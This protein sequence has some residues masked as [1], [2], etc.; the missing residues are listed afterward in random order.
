MSTFHTIWRSKW[1]NWTNTGF[2]CLVIAASGLAAGKECDS[3]C[4]LELINMRVQ[5]QTVKRSSHPEWNKVFVLWA[6][7]LICTNTDLDEIKS[8]TFNHTVSVWLCSLGG[9]KQGLKFFWPI[10]QILFGPFVAPWLISTQFS[11]LPFT[12][13]RKPSP[14]SSVVWLFPSWRHDFINCFSNLFSH[15]FYQ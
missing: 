10:T 11:M 15:P 9:M 4:L 1:C 14:N 6:H 2:L 12:T 3:Y 13:R 7:H 5:T 8:S